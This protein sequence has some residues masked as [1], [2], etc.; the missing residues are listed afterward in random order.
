MTGL[1]RTSARLIDLDAHLAQSIGDILTTPVGSRVMRRD[2]G[3]DLP[4]LIDAPMNGETMIDLFAATADALD[5]WEPR[6][7]LLR[8]QVTEATAG[9]MTLILTG[10]VQGVATTQEVAL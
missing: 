7:V 5:R 8:V 2:Y 4:L 3:S 10:E 1:S 9:R 6:Y